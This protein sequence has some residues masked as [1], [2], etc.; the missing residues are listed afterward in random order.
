MSTVWIKL[1]PTPNREALSIF[2]SY[3]PYL[4]CIPFSFS[5]VFTFYFHFQFLLSLFS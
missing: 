1:T 5:H 2:I 4:H 3:L